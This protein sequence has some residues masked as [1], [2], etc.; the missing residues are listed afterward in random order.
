M[1][2]TQKQTY[3]QFACELAKQAGDIMKHHYRT[4]YVAEIKDNDTP[5][6]IADTE[7][8]TMVIEKI[9]RTFPD[10]GVLGEEESWQTDAE[11]LWV[12]DPIDGTSAYIVHL[13]TSVFSIALV[14]DGQP[15]VAVAFNPWT[16]DTYTAI[17]GE[18]ALRNGQPIHVSDR[19]WDKAVLGMSGFERQPKKD[20]QAKVIAALKSEAMVT[21]FSGVIFQGCLLAEGALDGRVFFYE[22]TH[23]IASLKLIIE[24]AGGKVTD[25]MGNEQR[26]DA[27][28][29]G[30][31][32]SNG[33]IHKDIVKVTKRYANTRD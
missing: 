3:L 32:M 14:Q 18:G 13:P 11:T 10:H 20:F 7:I 29:N 1:N 5:V 6:T 19:S 31:I 33:H 27:P 25:I 15:V 24:E 26:Y 22:N 28:L 4:D 23:D 16:N 12:C 21:N 9:K 30:A 17:K 2:D 8:N